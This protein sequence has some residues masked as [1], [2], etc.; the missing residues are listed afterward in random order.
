ML[1]TFQGDDYMSNFFGF[2]FNMDIEL[3]DGLYVDYENMKEVRE[4]DLYRAI[5]KFPQE[6]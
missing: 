1:F 6:D 2:L 4:V 3:Y 5:W